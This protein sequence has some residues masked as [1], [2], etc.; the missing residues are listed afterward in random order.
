M[1]EGMREVGRA[2]P[3]GAMLGETETEAEI[4]TEIEI[5]I[6]IEI[7]IETETET[8]TGEQSGER[9]LWHQFFRIRR[10]PLPP[11]HM[12][13]SHTS[14]TAYMAS[15]M[16]STIVLIRVWETRGGMQRQRRG[17]TIVMSLPYTQS[18]GNL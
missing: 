9:P 6:E 3:A 15:A 5:K 12:T 14:V 2:G 13:V 18:H 7:E 16:I 10:E 8:G 1:I 4:E 11:K 17:G